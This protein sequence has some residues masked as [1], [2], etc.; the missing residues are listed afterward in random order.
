MFL[1]GAGLQRGPVRIGGHT[2]Q[3]RVGVSLGGTGLQ[4]GP[5]RI[6]GHTRNNLLVEGIIENSGFFR[7]GE[8]DIVGLGY[9]VW[10]GC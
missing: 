8:T 7:A 3:L 5:V 4:R 2:E 6:G 10:E 1:D 9:R